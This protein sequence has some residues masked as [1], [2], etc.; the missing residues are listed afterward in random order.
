MNRP[1]HPVI[2]TYLEAAAIELPPDL[3]DTGRKIAVVIIMEMQK[4]R[5]GI[6]EDIKQALKDDRGWLVKF[7]RD[8]AK[9]AAG[10]L[11]KLM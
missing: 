4:Q 9:T 1:D 8:M 7:L 5:Q 6:R 11:E 10:V 3:S 2:E